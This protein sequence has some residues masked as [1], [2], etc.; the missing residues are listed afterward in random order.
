MKTRKAVALAALVLGGV[1][2]GAA[3]TGLG[4]QLFSATPPPAGEEAADASGR[5]SEEAMPASVLTF[6]ALEHD[7]GVATMGRSLSH[8]FTVTNRGSQ[9]VRLWVERLTCNCLAIDCPESVGPGSTAAVIVRVETRNREGAF[10]TRPTLGT[11]DPGAPTIPLVV[12][13]RIPPTLDPDPPALQF[14]NVKRG[15]VIERDLAVRIRLPGEEG[16][17]P[18]LTIRSLLPGLTCRP[19][20]S[21]V[22]FDP[23]TGLR[24]AVHRYRVRLASGELPPGSETRVQGDLHIR[25][26]GGEAAQADKELPV[27]IS[28]RHHPGL[29]GPTSVTV[30][31]R[32]GA[33]EVKVRLWSLEDTTFAVTRVT[34]SLPGVTA[35]LSTS[36]LA[37]SHEVIVSAGPAES[38]AGAAK[39]LLE[40]HSP[41]YPGEPYWVHVLVLP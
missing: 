35:R 9:P 18:A 21:H 26:S 6:D 28:F 3:V 40:I 14:L 13:F 2:G 16:E 30:Q 29:G 15:A 23:A 25:A 8:T 22:T 34:T 37:R 11:S 36:G 31:R 33:S 7:F 10:A 4:R 32:K 24:R 39:V 17:G 5:P 27:E 1:A 19:I 41:Q 20:G 38:G 12:R